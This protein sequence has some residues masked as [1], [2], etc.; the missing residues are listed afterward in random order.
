MENICKVLDY[1]KYQSR[2][3]EKNNNNKAI[4]FREKIIFSVF[5]K[6]QKDGKLM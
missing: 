4:Y 2:E 1:S 6:L 5:Q 3:T